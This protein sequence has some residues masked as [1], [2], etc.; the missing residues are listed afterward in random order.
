[1]GRYLQ[2]TVARNGQGGRQR[3]LR[4]F[5]ALGGYADNL[6]IDLL[7]AIARNQRVTELL[8][9]TH[10]V[11]DRLRFLPAVIFFR[12]PFISLQ[13]PRTAFLLAMAMHDDAGDCG[14]Y[15]RRDTVVPETIE[16][17]YLVVLLEMGIVAFFVPG[18]GGFLL[19]EYRG[20]R[21]LFRRSRR[22][23]VYLVVEKYVHAAGHRSPVDASRTH[24]SQTD[25]DGFRIF[26]HGIARGKGRKHA[27]VHICRFVCRRLFPV[28]ATL[29]DDRNCNEC[30]ITA[31]PLVFTISAQRLQAEFDGFPRPDRSFVMLVIGLAILEIIDKVELASGEREGGLRLVAF[32]RHVVRPRG[33]NGEQQDGQAGGQTEVI[34]LHLRSGI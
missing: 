17:K 31:N 6:G 19:A 18:R 29:P 2:V 10:C 15:R 8:V 1:M 20:P 30:L 21:L 27:A 5:I 23:L 3:R 16:S 26:G 25:A 9:H 4:H 24:E 32:E 22:V 28:A 33:R 13:C 34:S 7:R 14:D 11:A 12:I